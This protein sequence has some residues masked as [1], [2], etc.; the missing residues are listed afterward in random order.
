MPG[1]QAGRRWGFHALRPEW[2]ERVV[3]AADVRCGEL[4][5]DVGAGT[6][7]LT[8]PLL[9]SGARVVAVELHPGRADRL[10][11]RFAGASVTVVE[12]DLLTV[13]LPR[14]PYRLVANPP[15]DLTAQL[16]RR[17]LDPRSRLHA[18]DL[19]LQHWDARRLAGRIGGRRWRAGTGLHVPRQAFR[20][21][22]RVD[23]AVLRLR[24][25]R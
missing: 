10:R 5:L 23:S 15:Y 3:E 24:V 13:P 8:A 18:A 7:A 20:P 22:P 19:V 14:R 6:G 4:V 9:D 1:G 17:L 2:A 11:T 16:L 25:R 12:T 21:A